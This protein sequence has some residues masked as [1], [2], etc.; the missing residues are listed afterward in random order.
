MS[1]NLVKKLAASRK[2]LCKKMGGARAN[3]FVQLC[4]LHSR[5]L[6]H[7]EHSIDKYIS[8]DVIFRMRDVIRISHYHVT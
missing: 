4:Y 3:C 6:Q 7:T 2:I 5:E 8:D 1:L